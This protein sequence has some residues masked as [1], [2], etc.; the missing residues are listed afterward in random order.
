MHVIL[1]LGLAIGLVVYLAG[2]VLL[3]GTQDQREPQMLESRIPFLDGLIGIFKHRANHLATLRGQYNVSIH[4]LRMPFQRLY[5]VHTP[6]LIQ[7][8]Q[9]KANASKFIPNLLD[10]GMLFS[11]LK[12]ES[13]TVLRESFQLH[14]NA[15]TMSVH[16]YLLSGST[17]KVVSRN[18]I[19][20]LSAGLTNCFEGHES[21]MML[22]SVRHELT[23]ALTGAMY[24]PKNLY[25]DPVIERSWCDFVPGITH[26]LY[27]RWPQITARKALQ[28]RDRVILA[29]QEYFEAGGHLQAFPMIAEMFESNMRSGLS[30]TEAAKMEIAT[31]L[32]MLSSG[33]NTTFWLLYHIYSDPIALN[34]V[35][36]ELLAQSIE[37]L[38]SGLTQRNILS[39]DTI[40]ERCPTLMAM[41][42][43]TLR[44]HSTVT[45]I[46]QVQQDT[47]LADQ[48]LLK[49]DAIIMIPGQSIHHNKDIWGGSADVFEHRRFLASESKKKLCSTSAFRPFG[50]GV[51]MCPGRHFSTN[52]ITSLVAM[53]VLQYDI[54]PTSG[55]W[56]APTK[57]NADMWNAMPKPDRD[58]EVKFRRRSQE[59]PAEW[60]FIWSDAQDAPPIS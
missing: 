22:D 59:K 54:M 30:S 32:A 35:R 36:E 2:Q 45:N 26:L 58:I 6:Y 24:G 5:V 8:I 55:V 11:G 33:A 28:A 48:Y 46:K 4:T 53:I 10:F 7:L 47:T 51:T 34:T 23:R 13:Q 16:K 18:A 21:T 15:F 40:K 19:R 1:A 31:S 20:I 27:C 14:G 9:S 3:H 44:F 12:P 29:F 56:I 39:L 49:K 57:R 17:L 38:E 42:N 60:S 25:D 43:E 50:A 37:D 52:V 41:L